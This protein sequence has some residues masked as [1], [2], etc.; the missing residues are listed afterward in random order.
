MERIPMFCSVCGSRLV[1]SSHI[2]SYDVY[3]GEPVTEERLHCTNPT[4]RS[5]KFTK[6]TIHHPSW[7]FTN[8][9]WVQN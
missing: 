2:E 9:S 8:N 5:N 1:P 6:T 4:V 7:E 3:T